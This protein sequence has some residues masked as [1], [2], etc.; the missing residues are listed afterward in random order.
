MGLLSGIHEGEMFIAATISAE[1][2]M[3][4]AWHL[5]LQ[6]EASLPEIGQPVGDQRDPGGEKGVLPL[7][8]YVRIQCEISQIRL[9]GAAGE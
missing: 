9:F 2:R 7:W 4:P 3:N 6:W 1:F 5:R 8:Q